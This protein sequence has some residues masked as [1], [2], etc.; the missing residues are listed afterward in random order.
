MK[1][2]FDY[3]RPYYDSEVPAAIQR[4]VSHPQFH[5]ALD[6]LF[7][8]EKHKQIIEDVSKV[9]TSIEF[10]KVFMLPAMKTVLEKTS[11]GLTFEGFENVR[12]GYPGVYISNHRDILLDSALLQVVLYELGLDAS[13]IAS[14][15]NLMVSDFVIDFCKV[16]KI[17]TVIREGAPRELLANSKILSAYIRHTV[18]DKKTSVWIAQ[19]KGRTK[20][21]LDKTETGILKM[22]TS[23]GPDDV[24]Q[25]IREVNIRPVSISYEWEPCDILKIKENYYARRGGYVKD[26]NEDFKSVIN[27]I[28]NDKGRI[29]IAIGKPVNTILDDI[30]DDMVKSAV[31]N[32]IAQFIDDQVYSL[33]KLWPSNYLAYDLKNGSGKYSSRYT[34]ATKEHFDERLKRVID[35][36][37]KDPEELTELFY[38][39]YANPV[40]QREIIESR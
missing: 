16:N 17:L 26:E 27:G 36:L 3:I 1:N 32:N 37:K 13:E 24:K 21:G 28:V 10:Q 25:A 34:A 29:H 23:T 15:S 8:A 33:Y 31:Y 22:L 9:K 11:D 18:L 6:Y 12:N 2:E 19:R 7:P 35:T 14:G 20:N 5:I 4:I 38:E 40:I 39:M 30:P